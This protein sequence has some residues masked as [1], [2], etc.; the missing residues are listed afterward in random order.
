MLCSYILVKLDITH[1]LNW[2]YI[3][4][5]LVLLKSYFAF[6]HFNLIFYC[7]KTMRTLKIDLFRT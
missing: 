4:V 6:Q 5:E 1:F 2:F 3:M 7:C